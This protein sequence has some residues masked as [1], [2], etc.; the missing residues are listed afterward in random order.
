MSIKSL[1][2]SNNSLALGMIFNNTKT[3]VKRGG[4]CL[5]QEKIILTIVVSRST[6]NANR[7]YVPHS[8]LC[9]C[10]GGGGGGGVGDCRFWEEKQPSSS[11][12]YYKR[13]T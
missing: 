11:F 3:R 9:N 4:I 2:S 1:A 7:K 10:R 12:S 5:K 6:F 8:V 13:M